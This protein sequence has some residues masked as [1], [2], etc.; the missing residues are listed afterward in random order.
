MV[1]GPDGALYI[2]GIGSTGN[3]RQND[4]L[5]YGLQRL[6]YNGKTAFEMLSVSARSNGVEITFT[7]PLAENQGY[8]ADEYDVQ[9]WWYLPTKDYGGPKLDEENL[10]IQSVN[11]SDDRKKVFLELDG[12]KEGHVVYIRLPFDWIS[13]SGQ[14]IWTTEAWYTMNKIPQDQLGFVNPAPAVRPANSLTDSEVAAGWKLLFDGETTNGWRNYR[15]ETIGTSWKVIDGALTLDSQQKDDGGWQAQDGGDIIT[16]GEYENFELRL[17]W[18]IAACGN[19]G[20]M[21]NVIES[22]KYNYVWETGP[23]MQILDNTCHPD[24]RFPTHRAGD[25]YDMIECSMV[26]VKPVGE[27]NKVRLIINNGKVE[28]WQNGRKV[29]EYELWTPAWDQMVANS[30]FNTMPGFGTG[31]KGH[32]SLQDHGDRVAFRNIKIRALAKEEVQ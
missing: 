14:S 2:G 32:I 28:H 15:K 6:E 12:M 23:E 30:K 7:E 8:T 1:W 27:W 22:E 4:K 18:K 26:T 5:W 25:L 31:R 16:A 10:R 24:A 19:S 13:E 17:E 21:F 11:I 20:I 29:V 3:W 9:Q